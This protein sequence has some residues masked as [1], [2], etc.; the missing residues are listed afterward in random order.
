MARSHRLSTDGAGGGAG[1]PR[2][3]DDL[4]EG[5][6][7]LVA[8][9][10]RAPQ[11]VL[12]GAHPADEQ[13]LARRTVTRPATSPAASSTGPP[14]ST[15]HQGPRSSR[16]ARAA[17]TRTTSSTWSHDRHDA[18]ELDEGAA[19]PQPAGRGVGAGGVA[20]VPLTAQRAR[21]GCPARTS[22]PWRCRAAGPRTARRP[23]PSWGRA[24]RGRPSRSCRRTHPCRPARARRAASRRRARS[25]RRG[26]RR[27]GRRP[28]AD[29]TNGGIISTVE[30]STSEPMSAPSDRSQAGVSPEE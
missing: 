15:A 22:R 7:E 8:P 23:G 2:R 26:C 20:V 28:D 27:R 17:T 16:A 11:R 10:E 29:R 25:R 6:G 9:D 14:S 1:E 21:A 3:R 30:A 4:D 5:V 13:P 19:H 18:A 12:G 24:D